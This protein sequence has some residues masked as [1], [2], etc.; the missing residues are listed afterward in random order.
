MKKK[1]KYIKRKPVS[2]YIG[3]IA[4]LKQS[5][6]QSRY[7]AAKAANREQLL[8]YLFI[9][10]RLSE[11]IQAEK[12]GA[13]V[14][15][16]IA[17]DLQEELPGLRGFSYRNLMKM[18]QFYGE[19]KAFLILPLP[20]AELEKYS[21]SKSGKSKN[22]ILPLPTAEL[23]KATK[24]SQVVRLKKAATPLLFDENRLNDFFSIS[25]THHIILLTKCKDLK[26]RLY[27]MQMAASEMWSVSAL[28]HNITS[29]L[30]KYRGKL[31][32]NFKAVLPDTMSA[33]AL[34][35]FKDEYLFDFMLLDDDADERVFEE[36]AVANIRKFIM[37]L[38]KGFSFIGNQYK[39]DVEGKEYFIDLLFYNRILQCLVVFELKRG[40]F[41]PEY[42]GK[43]NFY[44]NVLDDKIKLEHE[45]PRS[46]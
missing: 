44:L 8:L 5:I 42:A 7:Q 43:L 9:G 15:Q 45:K 16:Q 23:K 22:L 37:T 13:K 27:Y 10:K 26:G 14:L 29:K 30:Y 39:V 36:A 18:I 41:K 19:Y 2:E 40:K 4:E 20:T 12:W 6:I 25:F 32:N 35:A 21:N 17:N 33:A 1:Q 11:K 46:E 31:P 38:G 28:E 34:D 3:F 24:Q